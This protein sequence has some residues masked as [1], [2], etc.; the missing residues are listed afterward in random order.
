[1]LLSAD[2]LCALVPRLTTRARV[3]LV[4]HS[5]EDQKTSNTGKL[6][7]RCLTNSAVVR[8]GVEG[9]PMAAVH[10]S[11]GFEPVLLF[12]GPGA[13]PIGDFAHGARPIELFVP[14]GTWGQAQRA[15]QRVVGLGELP[16]ASITRAAPSDYRLRL[17][18]DPRRLSTLESIAEALAVLEGAAPEG[19]PDVRAELL[20]IFDVMVERSLKHRARRRRLSGQVNLGIEDP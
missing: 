11:A 10:P 4:L 17:S 13:R 5:L 7:V 16:C 2:C 12:P 8:R 9:Q 6:A 1:L 15:R 14:D 3:V 19:H 20:R 18:S